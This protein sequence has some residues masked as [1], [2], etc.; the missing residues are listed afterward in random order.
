MNR[1]KGIPLA[2]PIS[3][4]CGLPIGVMALPTFDPSAI[5]SRNGSGRSASGR[6]AASTSGVR[7]RQIVSLTKNAENIPL[8][9]DDRAE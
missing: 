2:T 9:R 6:S 7:T 4:F 8:D 5:A 1:A 3:M